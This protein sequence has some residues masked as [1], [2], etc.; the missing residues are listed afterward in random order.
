M[1]I[2]ILSVDDEPEMGDLIRLILD[3]VGYELVFSS[4]SSEAWELLHQESFDLLMQDLMR[5]GIDGWRF[6]LMIK[7][8]E[9]L[10]DLPIMIVTAKAQSVDKALGYYVAD[11]DAYVTKPFGPQELLAAL[12]FVLGKYG[13]PSPGKMWRGPNLQQS[14]EK[15]E[16]LESLIKVL[17]RR[18]RKK[19]ASAASALGASGDAR[20]VD[21]LIQALRD[22]ANSDY[23]TAVQAAY[24]LGKIGDE[25][26]VEP[27]IEVL[28]EGE[29]ASNTAA[30]VLG[31]LGDARAVEP[32]I[33][34]LG[35]RSECA[36]W[37]ATRSLARI[38]APAVEPLIARVQGAWYCAPRKAAVEALGQTKD[39]RAVEPLIA[40]LQDG[41]ADV[42]RT[43]AWYLGYLKDKRAVQP[44][45][46]TLQSEM[47]NRSSAP[48]LLETLWLR[49]ENAVACT[50]IRS[51]GYLGDETAV[52]PLT[53]ALQDESADVVWQAAD[54]LRMIGDI[55]AILDLERVAKE[56]SRKTQ[57]GGAV[58]KMAQ[59]AIEQ[60]EAV[61]Q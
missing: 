40:A 1:T 50:A 10:Y 38:G 42:R 34:E 54:A 44:L 61:Q 29:Y 27:L 22:Y 8:D 39:R 9:V 16:D 51:L 58:A 31:D 32:L 14:G 30:W 41:Y 15:R 5:P 53:A 21:P 59:Y 23:E 4:D 47:E 52:E 48:P 60:I 3:R 17:G 37:I 35:G 55:R 18:N 56:D 19:R 49:R 45:I 12:E 36:V 33:E 57:Y 13:K 20:A 6:Y 7:A 24:A 2:R 28:R 26:A 46:T 11:V 43:A 25:R